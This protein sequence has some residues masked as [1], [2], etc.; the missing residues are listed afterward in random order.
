M[1][2]LWNAVAAMPQLDRIDRLADQRAADAGGDGHGDDDGNNDRVVAR[3]LEDHDDSR[4]DAA[5]SRADHRSHA[6]DRGRRHGQTGIWKIMPT[7]TAN[8]PPSVAPR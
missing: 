5:G 2:L 1:P 6:D 3:H 8:A 7:A 4:H